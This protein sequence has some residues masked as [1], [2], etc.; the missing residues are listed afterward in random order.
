MA[1]SPLLALFF[2][3]V[4]ST[5]IFSANIF[6][7]DDFGSGFF[8]S[9]GVFL[10]SACGTGNKFSAGALTLR[11]GLVKAIGVLTLAIGVLIPAIGVAIDACLGF[12]LGFGVFTEALGFPFCSA[13]K[14]GFDWGFF[15]R[16]LLGLAGVTG[17]LHGY[18]NEFAII[19]DSRTSCRDAYSSMLVDTK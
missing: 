1:E 18:G 16:E 4:F 17:F 3:G 8:F 19:A 13:G 10:I 12:T 11:F 15:L 2:L 5:G 14:A 7:T 9:I 6:S